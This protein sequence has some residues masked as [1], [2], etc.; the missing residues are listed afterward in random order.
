MT[1]NKHS[2]SVVGSEYDLE[3]VFWLHFAKLLGACIR[4]VKFNDAHTRLHC[5]IFT[6]KGLH[7]HVY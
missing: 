1:I 5:P 7:A 2:I 3:I 6:N 4:L